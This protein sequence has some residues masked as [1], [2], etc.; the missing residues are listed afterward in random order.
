MMLSARLVLLSA[1]NRLRGL[2]PFK[3]KKLQEYEVEAAKENKNMTKAEIV[4]RKQARQR[5]SQLRIISGTV[6]GAFS[7]QIMGSRYH[8][9]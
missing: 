3:I 2:T 1:G 9:E 5:H 4:K 8:V 6:A 7:A